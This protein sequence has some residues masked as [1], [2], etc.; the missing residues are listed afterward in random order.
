MK[1]PTKIYQ[2]FIHGRAGTFQP[3]V[4]GKPVIKW[5]R[6][7][8]AGT[9]EFDVI[10]DN[11]ID[12]QEGDI[13]TFNINGETVFKGYVFRKSRSKTQIINTLCYDSIR[14]LKYADTYQYKE[15]SMSDLIKRICSDRGLP[16]GTIED[17]GYQIPKKIEKNQ[18]YLNM[19]KAADDI[20]LSQTGNL[21]TLYDENGKI[22]LKSPANMFVDYPVT[23]DNACDFDYV[24]SIDDGTYNRVVVYLTD[25]NGN[26]LKR[27]IKEDKANIAKWGVLEYTVVT[28][29]DEDIE[30]K[31]SQLLELLNRVYRSLVIKDVI[32][33]IRVRA[34]SL[35]PIR[36]MAIGDININS[37]MLVNRVTHTFYD[38]YHFMELEVFNKDIMP[39][40]DGSNI[41][42]NSQKQT[43]KDIKSGVMGDSNKKSTAPDPQG[44]GKVSSNLVRPVSGKVTSNYGNRTDPVYGGTRFHAGIDI[45]AP[46]GTPVKSVQGGIVTKS[47]FMAD[48]YGNW[49]EVKHPDGTS[50]RYA[51]LSTRDVV[52][53]QKVDSGQV[54]GKVGS[55][56]KSTGPHLHFEIRKGGNSVNPKNYINF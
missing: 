32:G 25:D 47:S 28:N 14:Y 13:V 38:D 49:V 33:D 30:N 20:T 31:A 15:Q 12:Y 22:N 55:T 48:G 45:G 19:I 50:S 1:I 43:T 26:Q 2:V 46:S 54:I 24:T 8:R 17:T 9:L 34:G 39:M 4:K 5:D 11:T 27:V 40:G 23:Y 53:G 36:L 51:H 37:L 3:L 16:T 29:N 18:E 35:I 7:F 6:K 44:S 42:Q 56:G 41:I 21:Y 52:V 10:K